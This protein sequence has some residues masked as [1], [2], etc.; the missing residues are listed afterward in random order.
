MMTGT[1][2][3][4]AWTGSRTKA[5]LKRPCCKGGD[6]K[7]LDWVQDKGQAQRALLQGGA[8]WKSLDCVQDKGQAQKALLEG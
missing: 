2:T 6:R 3:G 1:G 4:G 8:D 5:R 7:S